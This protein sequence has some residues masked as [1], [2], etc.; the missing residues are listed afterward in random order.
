M[1]D[2]WRGALLATRVL[3]AEPQVLEQQPELSP[4]APTPA[5][6]GAGGWKSGDSWF[7]TGHSINIDAL[8][9]A[10]SKRTEREAAEDDARRQ[11]GLAAAAVEAPDFDPAMFDAEAEISGVRTAAVYRLP[12]REGVFLI[13]CAP[14]DGVRVKTTFSP[15]KACAHALALFA[16]G[17]FAAASQ[18]F[19]T[20][21]QRGI[22]DPE[23]LA[24]ARAAS[25]RVNLKAGIKGETQ[26]KALET[27]ARFHEE[28]DQWE[29]SLICWHQIYRETSEPDRPLLEKLAALSVRTH[30]PNNAASFRQEIER[31]WPASTPP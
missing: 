14:K 18:A 7:A 26:L 11:L 16:A 5:W 28:R 3:A 4:R 30:R 13:A 29:Q 23:T 8:G 22:Q 10:K 2:G 6:E 1:V 12:G 9:E 25:A 15:G 19:S 27:L 21:T 24:Y 31:R 17:E 20:L